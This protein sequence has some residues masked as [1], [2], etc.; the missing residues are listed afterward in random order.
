MARLGFVWELGQ[1][2][3]YAAI[4][5]QLARL[6]H[7]QGHD[8]V[9]FVCDPAVAIAHLPAELGPMIQAPLPRPSP[10][11]GVRVQVSYASLLHNCGFAHADALAARLRSWRELFR[12]LGID[13]VAARHSPTAVLAARSL[14]LPLLHYGTRFSV[15]PPTTPWPSFRTDMKTSA[16][17]LRSNEAHLL[18]TMNTALSAIG[19]GQL[20]NPAAM[21][22]IPTTLLLG[23]PQTD[24]YAGSPRTAPHIGLPDLSFGETPEWTAVGG[25]PRLFV[26][27]LR[28]PTVSAWLNVLGGIPAHIMLRVGD[29]DLEATTLPD[30]V[31]L[32]TG[33]VNYRE[34]IADSDAVLGYGS[35]N[36]VC[37]A[38]LAG[39]PIAVIAHNPDQLLIAQR[40]QAQGLGPALPPSPDAASLQRL[41]NW[42]QLPEPAQAART[43]ADRC[44]TPPREQAIPTLLSHL[45]RAPACPL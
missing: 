4:I 33:A 14:G 29:H 16:E 26:N 23:Y 11:T 21:Y 43:L 41:T 24:H 27:L 5:G 31:Q 18:A 34:I 45:L 15:P 44:A 38:I 1:N 20:K 42:L 28:G 30:N 22:D 10:S 39:K 13:R 17:I 6:A 36:L 25:V 9:F 19:A 12:A 2:G 40:M 37:E 7:A 8:C 3:G 35:H 32:I